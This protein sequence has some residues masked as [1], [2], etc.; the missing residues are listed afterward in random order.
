MQSLSLGK[1]WKFEKLDFKA[2]RESIAEG[3]T[4]EGTNLDKKSGFQNEKYFH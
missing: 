4:H 2:A 3:P 1:Y